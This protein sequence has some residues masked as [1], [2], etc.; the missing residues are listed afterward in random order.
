MLSS[1]R[2]GS[3]IR[4]APLGQSNPGKNAK[5]FPNHRTSTVQTG[6]NLLLHNHVTRN[7]LCSAKSHPRSDQPEKAGHPKHRNP[8]PHKPAAAILTPDS[9]LLHSPILPFWLYSA[10]TA[11][12]P[13][14]A[15]SSPQN[16]ATLAPNAE[17]IHRPP[18]IPQNRRPGRCP[19]RGALCSRRRP[20]TAGAPTPP[21]RHPA[22]PSARHPPALLHALSPHLHRPPA[23]HA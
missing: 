22:P 7:W 18:R 13:N 11:K 10:E 21:I 16:S 15:T 20:N 12:L 2:E 19:R 14:S 8:P 5:E 23:C 17:Q 9:C 3:A 6:C 1:C 4:H